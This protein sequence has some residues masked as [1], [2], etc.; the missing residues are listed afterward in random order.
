M[1]I[2]N[3]DM[4]VMVSEESI[5]KTILQ[6]GLKFKRIGK[7]PLEQ[8][9][10]V[11]MLNPKTV[12]YEGMVM[13]DYIDHGEAY[14][15]YYGDKL[16]EISLLESNSKAKTAIYDFITLVA[17]DK[18]NSKKL[19][20]EESIKHV[21]LDFKLKFQRIDEFSFNETSFEKMRSMVALT[22]D[23]IFYKYGTKED[24]TRAHVL[25]HKSKMSQLPI[26]STINNVRSCI[27]DLLALIAKTEI[28]A[29]KSCGYKDIYSS[30]Y[31]D[32]AHI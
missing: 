29:E 15:L 16:L 12:L 32:N 4:Y 20:T 28:E 18:I 3:L 27:M 30:V 1:S 8:R 21:V 5:E 23:T 24:H 2:K 10:V 17:K 13:S 19:V 26:T 14:S 9:R 6:A 31:T 22:P 11:L 25:L 7:I